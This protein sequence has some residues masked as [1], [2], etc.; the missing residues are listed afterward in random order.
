[1]K[2]VIWIKPI[3]FTAILLMVACSEEK[4]SSDIEYKVTHYPVVK[5][6]E[7]TNLTD[8]TATL[9]GTVNA[10]GLS[11]TVIFEY[12]TTTSYGNS[13]TAS[14]SPVT[15]DGNTNVSAEISGLTPC[16]KYHFRIKAENS[17]WTDFYGSE[18]IF[19]SDLT[20]TDVDSNT[21]HGIRIGS[22]VWMQ[23]NLKT[24]R[25]SNG[26]AI[27][28]VTDD[29]AWSS[30][31]TGAYCWNSND[32]ATYKD[33]YG[34]LYNWYAVADIRNVCPTNWHVPSDAEWK[35]LNIYLGGV[36]TPRYTN[37]D[38]S[39]VGGK[40]KETGTTHWVS[41]N[42]GAT[43]ETGFAALPGG[44]RDSLGFSH[45]IGYSGGWWSSTENMTYTGWGRYLVYNRSRAD[46]SDY[47]KIYG[48]SVR[49]VRN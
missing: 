15:V 23:E 12:D 4:T 47:Y 14:Q 40:L 19:N 24:T 25:Y 39:K 7:V 34:A 16:S 5:T 29:A 27:P 1:M 30:L 13:V 43:N 6:L 31:V 18:K 42:I 37:L 21:Y 45:T 2:K 20:V 11:T 17:L 35:T 8:T 41:P 44:Y 33:V 32:A 28:N 46:R 38:T 36:E 10:F 22:Q 9:N 48:F 49:C 26:D 3:I